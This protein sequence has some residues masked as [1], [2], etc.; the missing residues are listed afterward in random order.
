MAK[1]NVTSLNYLAVGQN[2]AIVNMD[3]QL[4]YQLYDKI[5]FLSAES[6]SIGYKT[7]L[8]KRTDSKSQLSCH[9]I[10]VENGNGYYY[11]TNYI[12]RATSK[13]FSTEMSSTQLVLNERQD[14]FIE[15]NASSK[16]YIRLF[17][18]C[19]TE[20]MTRKIEQFN[21]NRFTPNCTMIAIE[22]GALEDGKKNALTSRVD[23]LIVHGLYDIRDVSLKKLGT[24]QRKNTAIADT[25]IHHDI[26]VPQMKSMPLGFCQTSMQNDFQNDAIVLTKPTKLDPCIFKSNLDS[27][28][29]NDIPVNDY[30]MS[31]QSKQ[32]KTYVYGPLDFSKAV[33]DNFSPKVNYATLSRSYIVDMPVSRKS[34]VASDI[35]SYDDGVSYFRRLLISK[36]A[37]DSQYSMSMQHLSSLDNCREYIEVKSC[38]GMPYLKFY[39]NVNC[40]GNRTDEQLMETSSLADLDVELSGIGSDYHDF[41]KIEYMYPLDYHAATKHKSNLYSIVISETGIEDIEDKLEEAKTSGK[42]YIQLENGQKSDMITTSKQL[43]QLKFEIMAAVREIAVRVAPANTQL[44][45]IKFQS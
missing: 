1:Y 20:E 15:T 45:D 2:R 25:D 42:S 24:K 10:G 30:A 28:R 32:A 16:P 41:Q 23:N 22:N 12:A 35:P 36:S 40:I 6:N 21:I 9:D 13:P 29:D 3:M 8:D 39:D 11:P 43:D 33:Q 37:L 17:L 44:F 14:H 38:A 18:S 7:Y 34:S 27:T 19:C 31:L 4:E 26:Y 5:H